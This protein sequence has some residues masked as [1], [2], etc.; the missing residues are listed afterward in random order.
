MK[1][2]NNSPKL[3]LKQL[4]AILPKEKEEQIALVEWMKYVFHDS[5]YIHV[6]N[7]NTVL[8]LLPKNL[9]YKVLASLM[10]MGMKKGFPD[11]LIFRTLIIK[12]VTYKGLVIEMKR[13]KP[14]H[15]ELSNEQIYWITEMRER[16]GWYSIICYGAEA[17]K[18]AISE[19][20]GLEDN[21]GK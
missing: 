14:L 12:D 11:I 5:E 1:N 8:S 19:L 7:E 13:Q 20:Y 4:R 15:S 21:N 18:T 17:A 16:N 3:T 9:V 10:K 2:N 6:A